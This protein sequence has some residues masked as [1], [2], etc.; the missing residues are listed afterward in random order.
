MRVETL[1]T[2][3]GTCSLCDSRIAG[4]AVRLTPDSPMRLDSRLVCLSCY[5]MARQA[6]EK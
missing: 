4:E 5:L 3:T 2:V 1:E 6:G